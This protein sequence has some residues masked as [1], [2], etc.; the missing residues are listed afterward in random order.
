[1][2][3]LT[4]E[5]IKKNN[6]LIKIEITKRKI[7]WAIN[8]V[9][10]FFVYYNFRERSMIHRLRQ[11]F[12]SD[13]YAREMFARPDIWSGQVEIAQSKAI[14]SLLRRSRYYSEN[15]VEN[16]NRWR[17]RHGW[18]NMFDRNTKILKTIRSNVILLLRETFL[19]EFGKIELSYYIPRFW[20]IKIDDVLSRLNTVTERDFYEIMK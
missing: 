7:Y 20:V 10:T 5:Y 18:K 8:V 16:D 14:N 6:V 2:L 13:L 17:K 15:F 1:M 12:I 4:R 3:Y 9:D 11:T 19:Y